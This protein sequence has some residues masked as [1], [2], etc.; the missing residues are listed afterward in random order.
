MQPLYRVAWR[1]L[2]RHPWQTV[3]MIVGITL[4]VAVMVAIDLANSAASHAFDLSTDTIAGK[5]THQIVGGPAGLDETIYRACES[6]GASPVR[7]SCRIT[8]PPP[9]WATGR[10]N[11]LG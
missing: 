6:P 2:L 9:S 11:C 3:L 5:A 1:Y 10:S 4:G 8:S 7:R